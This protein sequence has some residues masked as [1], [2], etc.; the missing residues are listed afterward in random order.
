MAD[1]SHRA[2]G[3][4]LLA[5]AIAGTARAQTCTVPGARPTVQQAVD[6]PSCTTIQLAKQT[7]AESVLVQRSLILAGAGVASTIAGQ[8]SAAG[9]DVVVAVSNLQVSNG[10][11]ETLAA[12]N[13][14]RID[15]T[16]VQ[17][18]HSSALG[19]GGG[20]IFR[21]GFESGGTHSWSFSTPEREPRYPLLPSSA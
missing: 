14:A 13:G 3:A 7:F 5:L 17:A 2:I 15:A 8:L 1:A 11:P 19:C 16:G 18:T 20:R 6:D 9:A 10:C 21:D 12:R 4:L